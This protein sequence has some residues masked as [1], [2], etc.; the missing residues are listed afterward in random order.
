MLGVT[1]GSAW[2][3]SSRNIQGWVPIQSCALPAP[4]SW[5]N[6][7]WRVFMALNASDLGFYI[8]RETKCWG[9]QPAPG[10]RDWLEWGM[11]QDLILRLHLHPCADTSQPLHL[12]RCFSPFLVPNLISNSLLNHSLRNC[13]ANKLWAW[14]LE[15]NNLIIGCCLFSSL[16]D[17]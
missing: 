3:N 16:K 14:A 6:F 2:S 9:S 10:W 17:L 5:L 4:P 1:A 8:S 7:Q 11:G 13:F 15:E 12:C